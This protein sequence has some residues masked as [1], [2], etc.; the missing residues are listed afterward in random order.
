MR[1]ADAWDVFLGYIAKAR[2]RVDDRYA[3]VALICLQATA[4]PDGSV[5]TFPD[6][7]PI[8]I[9]PADVPVGERGDLL[10]HIA[11]MYHANRVLRSN[12]LGEVQ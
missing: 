6:K 7:D 8:I 3:P 11:K 2:P 5:D 12:E 1:L 9:W 10:L 4:N